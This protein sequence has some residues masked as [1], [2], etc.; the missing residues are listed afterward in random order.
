MAKLVLTDI[1][2]SYAS[3]A[4]LN[5]N[6]ALTETAL[7]NTLSRDGTAPNTML[8]DID[9]N[10]NDLLNVNSIL[11]Q[12][13]KDSSGNLVSLAD[14]NTLGAIVA[15]LELLA[16]IQDG[17]IATNAITTVAAN[18]ANV[19]TVAGISSNVT[20]VA[21]INADVTTVAGISGDVS[22]VATNVA[23]VTNF[24]DVYQ[25]GKAIAP[26]LRNDGSSLQIGDLYFNTNANQLAVYTGITWVSGTA[27]TLAV[28]N[29]TGDGTTT[30]FTLAT[31]P[32]SEDNTQ[33]YIDGVY[34]Q[35]NTYSISGVT[36]TFSEAPPIGTSNIE[37]VNIE[38]LALGSSAASLTSYIPSGVGAVQTTV[39][40]KL[41]ESVSVKDFGAVGDGV[42]DDSAVLH[43]A[44]EAAIAAGTSLFIPAGIYLISTS[45]SMQL[46]NIS[47]HG[48]GDSSVL[49][50]RSTVTTPDL[51][52]VSIVGSNV[53]LRALAFDLERTTYTAAKAVSFDGTASNIEIDSC[54]FFSTA[55]TGNR[56]L[57]MNGFNVFNLTISNSLFDF[58]ETAIA[59]DNADTSTQRT[60]KY[61]GNTVTN[62][63]DG[64][65][66]NSPLGEWTDVEII[67]NT[68]L[69]TSQFPVALAGA[70]CRNV[71]IS[72]NSFRDIGRHG[73]HIEASSNNVS[74]ANNVF[75]DT[76]NDLN[77]LE[78]G[79]VHIITGSY[80]IS[81]TGNTFDLT[82]TGTPVG[83]SILAGGTGDPKNVTVIGN[84]FSCSSITQA[85]VLAYITTGCVVSNNS[86]T[87]LSSASK[88][89]ATNA[90]IKANKSVLSGV[91]NT[92]YN[93]GSI[94]SVD[95]DSYV[96]VDSSIIDGDLTNFDFLVNNANDALSV[97]FNDFT[98]RRAFTADSTPQWNIVFPAGAIFR[99]HVAGK[100]VSGYGAA[101]AVVELVDLV[102][103]NTTLTVTNLDA[104]ASGGDTTAPTTAD[105]QVNAGNVEH[106]INKTSSLTAEIVLRFNGAFFP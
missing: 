40:D 9:L 100:F 8:A 72:G 55:T 65:N 87:N 66:V 67:G 41:R 12:Y 61:I 57:Y 42:T 74:V 98:I 32:E 54:T 15:D 92:F 38:T 80:N 58:L 17:T 31:A 68:F 49:K 46:Q 90:F 71:T 14:V 23:D 2:G 30:A 59:K 13:F 84:V 21:G 5:A 91:G 34:Q 52:A 103:D 25:G 4:A 101:S 83:V 89:T 70:N 20:T 39:Q 50:V 73:V 106:R 24:A 75:F 36:L 11:A 47:V 19:T 33:V 7:E 29:F 28:V 95:D 51:A 82:Q 3:V 22:T 35:K 81:V 79:N 53:T 105:W 37:V 26:T 44:A 18:S 1:T 102:W 27:G 76:A 64:F 99:G 94:L 43:T 60:H 104:I 48:E 78:D 85:A 86:F 63:I 16:D 62:C 6:F 96:G 97:A 10:S 45:S 56:A 88:I 69:S 93:P 77:S